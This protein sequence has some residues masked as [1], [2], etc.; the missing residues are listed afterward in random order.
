MFSY[1]V[2]ALRLSGTGRQTRSPSISSKHFPIALFLQ[3]I[4]DVVGWCR[5]HQRSL[6][7]DLARVS[8]S[9][10]LQHLRNDLDVALM[11]HARADKTQI[12]LLF[13]IVE[14]N[15]AD[16]VVGIAFG[17]VRALLTSGSAIIGST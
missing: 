5:N 14:R 3:L 17:D 16:R 11:H 10:L 1:S 9:R 6:E 7:L 8:F 12:H 15:R 13:C 4:N 2:R